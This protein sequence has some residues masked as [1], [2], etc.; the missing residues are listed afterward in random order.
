M[1]TGQYDASYGRNAGAN[2]DVIT[3]SG[4][5]QFHGNLF[6]FFRNED[7]NANSFFFNEAGVP[8]GI[9]RQNQFGGTFGGPILK[10]KLLFFG[11]YQGTRQINGVT[12]GCSATFDGAPLTNDRSAAALGALFGGQSG[13]NGG[14]A[15]AHDGSN[16]NPVALTLLN[17]KLPNGTYVVPT[18]QA[19][20]NGQGQYAF[21]IPCTYNEDQFMVNVDWLQSSKSKFAAKYFFS[22]ATELQS[23]IW[24]NVPGSP[25]DG[26]QNY[27]NLSVTHDFVFSPTM[28]NQV[29]FGFHS[30]VRGFPSPSS[31]TFP[32]IG[33]SV[34]PESTN[35]AYIELPN[36]NIGAFENGFIT[37]KAYTLQDTFTYNRGRHNFRFGGGATR[38]H[39]PFDIFVSSIAQ[40]LSF[41]DLLLGLSAAQ[42][43]SAYSNIYD[44]SSFTGS[45]GRD[46]LQYNY[47]LYAQD[48]FRVNPRLTLNLGL[49]YE[50][51]GYLGDQNGK[52]VGFSFALANPNP[53]ASGS[54][55][56]YV[57]PANYHGPI[58]AGSIKVNNDWATYGDGQNTLGPRLGF[59]WQVLPKSTRFVLRGGYGIYYSTQV[60]EAIWQENGN[61]P[62]VIAQ[63]PGGTANAGSS[64]ATPFRSR[65]PL[66]CRSSSPIHPAPN[67]RASVTRQRPIAVLL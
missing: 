14:V 52:S 26:T 45:L 12:S 16:I 4:S 7:L 8:R 65:I 58:P 1:V 22:D 30:I 46:Y 25:V 55:A 64:L 47:W 40:F 9:L 13:A 34:N 35:F 37:N 36:E 51:P 41:P 29:E 62:W 57:L 11:S 21:S 48:D 50:H 31:F 33:A 53:P 2:V 60:G 5:N 43:G 67:W 18:P 17:L 39:V 20:V 59:A 38:T 15:V 42:N 28:L 32:Q 24:S 66:T 6:E 27:R 61:P 44:T 63:Q 56:G 23:L 3:K 54:E 19:I 49:R 10:D